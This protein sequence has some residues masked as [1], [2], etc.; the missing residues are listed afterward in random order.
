MDGLINNVVWLAY[1]VLSFFPV[2]SHNNNAQSSRIFSSLG[3]QP[4]WLP[5]RVNSYSPNVDWSLPTYLNYSYLSLGF[6]L[7]F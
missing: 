1:L 6:Y 3:G 7:L 5:E 2:Q 4:D